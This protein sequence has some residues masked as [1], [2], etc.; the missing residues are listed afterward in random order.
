MT[1][2]VDLFGPRGKIGF[3]YTPHGYY[4]GRRWWPY[5]SSVSLSLFVF[6]ILGFGSLPEGGWSSE[7]VWWA[8]QWEF[9]LVLLPLTFIACFL[10]PYLYRTHAETQ[11]PEGA[12]S[13]SFRNFLCLPPEQQ[14][15]LGGRKRFYSDLVELNEEDAVLVQ[16]KIYDL[17]NAVERDKKA[18]YDYS[19]AKNIISLVT[20]ETE[21]LTS[22]AVEVEKMMKELT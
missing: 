22:R 7:P 6:M 14:A 5:V 2:H 11:L 4:H 9:L 18:N 8:W 16:D 19:R 1:H 17:A 20:E 21:N 10:F 12:H 13:Q 15:L 3:H